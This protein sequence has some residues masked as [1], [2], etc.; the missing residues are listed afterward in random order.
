MHRRFDVNV[1]LPPLEPLA[2]P[3]LSSSKSSLFVNNEEQWLHLLET[4]TP[5]KKS[6]DLDCIVKPPTF[7][8]LDKGNEDDTADLDVQRI[9]R[10]HIN[11]VLKTRSCHISKSEP[12]VLWSQV[13]MARNAHRL[14]R[15]ET[16]GG[17][18]SPTG[19]PATQR[20]KV[21]GPTSA[22]S[23][24]SKW[25]LDCDT[26]LSN[27]SDRIPDLVAISYWV[28][29]GHSDW[30]VPSSQ[31]NSQPG[32]LTATPRKSVQTPLVGSFKKAPSQLCR[33]IP[34]QGE[35]EQEKEQTVEGIK[36]HWCECDAKL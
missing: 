12:I 8:V 19:S 5:P 29:C 17:N 26:N 7:V 21:M 6:Q 4:L 22:S 36:A 1:Q 31:R 11:S 28:N 10:T 13:S 3:R 25:K 34:A 9:Q 35:K 14:R 33:S 23:L 16:S 2:P 32:S 24:T 27:K 30:S 18:A 15:L 20:R